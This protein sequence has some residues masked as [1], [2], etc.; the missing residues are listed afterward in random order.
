[1]IELLLDVEAIV[2]DALER[3]RALEFYRV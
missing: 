2:L 1:L 3:T